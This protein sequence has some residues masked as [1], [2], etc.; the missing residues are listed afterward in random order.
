MLKKG[1]KGDYL[2]AMYRPAEGESMQSNGQ[3]VI[4]LT[5]ARC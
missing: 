2:L 5:S 1:E 3:T 4:L